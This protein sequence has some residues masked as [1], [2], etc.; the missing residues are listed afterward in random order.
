MLMPFYGMFKNSEELLPWGISV[1]RENCVMF[2]CSLM[3]SYT[4]SFLL[5]WRTN[6]EWQC[7]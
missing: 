6:R 3:G 2:P 4:S 1:L 7:A 5:R